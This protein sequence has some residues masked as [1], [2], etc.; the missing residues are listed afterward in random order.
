M[1]TTDYA[2]RT[3][4]NAAKQPGSVTTEIVNRGILLKQASSTVVA[5]EYMMARGI[6]S[7]VIRRVLNGQSLRAADRATLA[8]YER[9]LDRIRQQ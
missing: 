9:S 4:D 7:T 2:R 3:T 1:Q 6:D 5:V 8:I